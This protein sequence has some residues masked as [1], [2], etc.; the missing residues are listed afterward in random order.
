MIVDEEIDENV[1]PH[2]KCKRVTR[3]QSEI[4]HE[5]AALLQ[6]SRSIKVERRI[7]PCFAG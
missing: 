1:I 4:D 6:A 7:A 2:R 5:I 3:S